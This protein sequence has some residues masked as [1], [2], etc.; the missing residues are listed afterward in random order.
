MRPIVLI[1]MQIIEHQSLDGNFI[2]LKDAA[3]SCLG[4]ICIDCPQLLQLVDVKVILDLTNLKR[5]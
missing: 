3:V 2:I 5:I 1:L 4:C